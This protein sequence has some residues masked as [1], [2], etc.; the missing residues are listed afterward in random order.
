[1]TRPRPPRCHSVLVNGNVKCRCRLPNHHLTDH[2]WWGG[3]ARV[4]WT[5]RGV[6]VDTNS[7][8]WRDGKT[9]KVTV[10]P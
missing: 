1:M 5:D 10:A 4:E 2:A 6:V 9:Y 3:A 8:V 7:V